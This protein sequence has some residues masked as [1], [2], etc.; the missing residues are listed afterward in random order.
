MR[1]STFATAMAVAVS[2]ASSAW[3]MGTNPVGHAPEINSA[4]SLTALVAVAALAGFIGERRR[5]RSQQ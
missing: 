3:A 4:G 5:R 2:L 1:L